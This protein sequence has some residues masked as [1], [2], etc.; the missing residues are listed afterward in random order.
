MH[1]VAHMHTHTPVTEQVCLQT[2]TYKM[3][4]FKVFCLFAYSLHSCKCQQKRVRCPSSPS[5]NQEGATL[6][7]LRK[8]SLNSV[9]FYFWKLCIAIHSIEV[10]TS[11]TIFWSAH[12]Q[13]ITVK[14]NQHNCKVLCAYYSS[15]VKYKYVYIT[16]CQNDCHFCR[17]K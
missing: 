10:W 1:P 11:Y 7:K 16:E 14:Q 3:D 5:R 15:C 8:C 6:S 17:Q 2:H 9:H 13:Q 4:N 12:V